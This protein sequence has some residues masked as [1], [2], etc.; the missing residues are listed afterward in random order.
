MKTWGG[1]KRPK[2]TLV[3]P[4]TNTNFSTINRKK[5]EKVLFFFLIFFPSVDWSQRLESKYT[6]LPFESSYVPGTQRQWIRWREATLF[7]ITNCGTG[8][9]I[10]FYGNQTWAF[11]AWKCLASWFEHMEPVTT[12]GNFGKWRIFEMALWKISNFVISTFVV[13]RFDPFWVTEIFRN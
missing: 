1:C 4:K 3:F 13:T 7:P 6:S 5:V 9:P 2:Q 11:E 8:F 10:F 12:L